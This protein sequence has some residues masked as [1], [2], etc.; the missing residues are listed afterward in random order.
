MVANKVNKE[1]KRQRILQAC[2]LCRLKK[3]R[4]DGI[5][6]KCENCRIRGLECEF[7]PEQSKKRGL[8]AGRHRKLMHHKILSEFLLGGLLERVPAMEEMMREILDRGENMLVSE[9]SR[10]RGRWR[11][12]TAYTP[13]HGHLANTVFVG[14]QETYDAHFDDSP[15]S[16]SNDISLNNYSS[17]EHFNAP[18]QMISPDYALLTAYA[19]FHDILLRQASP[20]DIASVDMTKTIPE[21]NQLLKQYFDTYHCSLPVL[22]KTY[23][24]RFFHDPKILVSP[25]SE[26]RQHYLNQGI[27]IILWSACAL[28]SP[29]EGNNNHIQS[30]RRRAIGLVTAGRSSES[31]AIER[32]L[33]LL[34]LV[35]DLLRE[36]AWLQARDV[37][38][39]ACDISM[40][41]SLFADEPG[42]TWQ[43]HI[44]AK[45]R[46][47]VWAGCFLLDTLVASV[48]HVSPRTQAHNCSVPTISDEEW[49]EWDE[50]V[51]QGPTEMIRR[52]PGRLAHMFNNYLSSTVFHG[53]RRMDG[54]KAGIESL[55]ASY[56]ILKQDLEVWVEGLPEDLR[57]AVLG[58]G[59]NI[60]KA[61]PSYVLELAIA[62]NAFLAFASD[63]LASFVGTC[64]IAQECLD[65]FSGV[66]EAATQARNQVFLLSGRHAA[67]Y[68]PRTRH[69]TLNAIL[70][71]V[72]SPG[73]IGSQDSKYGAGS[74]LETNVAMDTAF[75][76]ST[77]SLSFL[78]NPMPTSSPTVLWQNHLRYGEEAFSNE[79]VST[80]S[81]AITPDDADTPH[82]TP[83]FEQW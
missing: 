66:S 35:S 41:H 53:S 11:Q 62:Y 38:S 2:N 8:P 26:D 52:A 39:L 51:F 17:P 19:S 75:T 68:G 81:F 47:K 9:R 12:C 29:L 78:N 54:T 1:Q 15:D 55:L 20:R 64:G 60:E 27:S 56:N 77:G 59:S 30:S 76:A 31:S 16:Q 46:R 7:T 82:N 50:W 70:Q 83:P 40:R 36:G 33:V 73:S 42:E 34:L 24:L 57:N 72:R 14:D 28:G 25:N 44:Q 63:G 45:R 65:W 3:R 22:D 58:I 48:L 37:I 67:L 10:L 13:F 69:P 32:V 23:L 79:L 49:E 43:Q 74:T 80:D 5:S 21:A 61:Q 18:V 4:C 6:P 71:L